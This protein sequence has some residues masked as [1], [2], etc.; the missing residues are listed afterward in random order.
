MVRCRFLAMPNKLLTLS[1]S[2][3]SSQ[4]RKF[5]GSISSTLATHGEIDD[6]L[7]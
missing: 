1:S 3:N 2:G 4:Q 6:N 7:S 5:G